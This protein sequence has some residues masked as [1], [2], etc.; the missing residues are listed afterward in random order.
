MLIHQNFVVVAFSLS[1]NHLLRVPKK[2]LNRPPNNLVRKDFRDENLGEEVIT[3]SG[4]AR[5][6]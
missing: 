4:F 3:K 5:H 1:R 2:R 6:F